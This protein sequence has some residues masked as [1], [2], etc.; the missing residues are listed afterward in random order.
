MLIRINEQLDELIRKAIWAIPGT[1]VQHFKELA[2]K[3][4]FTNQQEADYYIKKGIIAIEKEDIEELK[5]I[6]S[7]LWL[8]IPEEDSEKTILS[9]ITR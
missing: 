1:W 2:Q 4:N 6:V 3:G 7:E 9:G 5:R 8:L